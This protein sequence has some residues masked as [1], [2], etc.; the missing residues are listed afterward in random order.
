MKELDE[1]TRKKL[2]GKGDISRGA[3]SKVDDDALIEAITRIAI[4]GSAAHERRRQDVIRS[5]KTIDQ[6]TVALQQEGFDIKRSTVYLRVIPR[7]ALSREGKRHVNVAPVKL[8]RGS[9][10]KHANHVATKFAR[11]TINSLEEISGIL[12]PTQ[13][14]FHSQ[15]DKA[16]IALGLPAAKKQTPILMHMEYKVRLP[17]HDF[18]VARLHKLIPSVIGDMKIKPQT[19]S[20][21]A[22]TY[23]G[24]TYVA[25]RSAKHSGSSA[26]HHLQDMK[27]I[28]SLP[29]FESSFTNGDGIKPV[30]IV[31]VDGGPDENPRYKKTLYCAIDYFCSFDLDALFIATN[32]PGRSAFNRAERR[33][34]PLSKELAGVVL[35]HDNFGTHL[36]EKGETIDDDLELRNFEYAGR[37]LAEIWS[38]LVFD[39]H[40]TVAEYI[41]DEPQDQ[42]D[43][44]E[45]SEEWKATHVRHSQYFLQ[46]V[47]CNEID[48]CLPFRSGLLTILKD[49]FLPPPIPVTQTTT[50]LKWVR[51]DEG[52]AKY[53]SLTQNLAMR[54]VLKPVST[55]GKVIP[56]DYSNPAVDRATIDKRTCKHCSLY[57]GAINVKDSHEKT[58]SSKPTSR[59]NTNKAKAT[60]S[61]DGEIQNLEAREDSS[62]I[63]TRPIR[64]CRVKARRGIE[65]LCMMGDDD[66]DYEWHDEDECDLEG[67]AIPPDVTF[68]HG[69]PLLEDAD[70]I[71][72]TDA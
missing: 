22:V 70:P 3:P 10:D 32:A 24:S 52:G 62:N 33:M 4:Q 39:S 72:T 25:I 43:L 28:R 31:T 41:S 44:I 57:F 59:K 51:N 63:S 60:T 36:N 47:K 35:P 42:D 12:G 15:D 6:L 1:E 14:T 26:L 53:L 55:K 2:T 19:L 67:L 64:P 30:M 13:V 23:S 66:F 54:E 65:L 56:Y 37:I 29:E 48:C 11:S 69:T 71:W 9:N 5:V 16:K 38:S 20:S 7:F 46:I 45:T 21:D 34:A 8:F 18:V 58:C 68:Q 40:P 27:R 49:R 61:K 17:D 50:G